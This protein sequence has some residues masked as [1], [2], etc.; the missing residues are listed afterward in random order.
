M[1]KRFGYHMESELFLPL[2]ELN[3][4]YYNKLLTCQGIVTEISS[5]F[6]DD[7]YGFIQII[8]LQSLKKNNR[9]IGIQRGIDI[10]LREIYIGKMSLGDKV[11]I[12]G[13]LRV[14]NAHNSRSRNLAIL[15]KNI[16]IINDGDYINL[17]EQEIKKFETIAKQPSVQQKLAN[18]LFDNLLIEDHIKL[19]GT[20]ILFCADSPIL[21]ENGIH[22]NIGF[23]IIGASGAYKTTYLRTLKELFPNHVFQFSQKSDVKF[24]T[25]KSRYKIGG[26][27]CKKAGLADFAKNGIVLIDNLEELKSYK[28]S[29]LD[30]NFRNILRKS[31]II[32]AAHPKKD[33]YNDKKAVHDNLQFPRK[34]DLLRKFDI[35]LVS[36][37]KPD[38]KIDNVEE[39]NAIRTEKLNKN[40]LI[41]KDLL[42]KYIIYAKRKYDPK[43]S[44]EKVSKQIIKF[45]EEVLSLN[46]KKNKIGEIDPNNLVRVL[47]MLCKAHARLALKN[48]INE[49][50]V[51][52][53][54]GIY[55]KSLINLDLI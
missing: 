38:R 42:R 41:S 36:S 18:Y 23:L 4:S 33:Q 30:K 49:K 8:F 21:F 9:Q 32:A 31:S 15:S 39:I 10:I 47:T 26:H 6:E 53:I 20:L 48:E 3:F 14:Y 29:N 22:C 55:K 34:N 16:K 7:N 45:K 37:N 28:L 40:F 50:D 13:V 35:V 27:F 52:E 12:T 2:D 24:I 17:T 25:Y 11:Q 51:L 44:E 43:F 19:I 5:E 1:L 46:E 54:I